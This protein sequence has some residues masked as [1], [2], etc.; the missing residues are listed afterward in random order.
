MR[1][2]INTID[3]VVLLP[4]LPSLTVKVMVGDDIIEGSL[5]KRGLG[6]SRLL[7]EIVSLLW[8]KTNNQELIQESYQR[9][10]DL[11]TVRIQDQDSRL[12]VLREDVDMLIGRLAGTRE[13]NGYPITDV[14]E[15]NSP[16]VQSPGLSASL[17]DVF[18]QLEFLNDK[19]EKVGSVSSY[20]DDKKSGSLLSLNMVEEPGLENIRLD[21]VF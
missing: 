17:Q 4:I 18:R 2:E 3:S 1:V 19:A 5:E 9:D 16:E 11:L 14:P 21:S 6:E 12:Q 7:T 10:M 15:G 8:Q 13:Y 20:S